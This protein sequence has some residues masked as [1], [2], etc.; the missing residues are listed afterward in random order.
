[1]DRLTAELLARPHKSYSKYSNTMYT[2]PACGAGH[3]YRRS[4][5][6]SYFSRT[7]SCFIFFTETW[8]E[9]GYTNTAQTLCRDMNTSVSRP[10]MTRAVLVAW[11]TNHCNWFTSLSLISTDSS[12]RMKGSW[13]AQIIG[14][15]SVIYSLDFYQSNYLAVIHRRDQIKFPLEFIHVLARSLGHHLH[16][17]DPATR[18]QALAMLVK[19]AAG[20]AWITVDISTKRKVENTPVVLQMLCV[21]RSECWLSVSYPVRLSTGTAEPPN[22]MIQEHNISS[23]SGSYQAQRYIFECMV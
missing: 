21:G 19:F 2:S 6:R 16:V 18:Q 22:Y 7:M 11:C 12:S 3:G 20:S 10:N 14:W 9:G 4:S 1:M 13:S 15:V 8:H 17:V 23:T 5:W